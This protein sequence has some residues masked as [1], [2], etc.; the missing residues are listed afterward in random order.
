[1][2]I[3]EIKQ[4]FIHHKPILLYDPERENEVDFV[5]PTAYIQEST[6]NFMLQYGK[7]LLCCALDQD[8]LLKK[9]FF[10]L[11]SNHKDSLS[12]NFFIPV[13]HRSVYTGIS[14]KDRIATLHS[15]A[16][17]NSIEDY[18]YPG[19]V[20]LLGGIGLNK[21]KGHTEAALE[22]CEL[23]G[24]SRTA[25]I[26]E[27]LDHQ[28]ESHTI[29][30]AKSI[31]KDFDLPFCSIQD[32]FAQSIQQKPFVKIV[33]HAA[34]PTEFGNF[35]IVGF[36]NQLDTREHFALVKGDVTTGEVLVRIHSEC[37]TGDV[38]HSKK[39]DCRDQ[40]VK[41]MQLLEEAQKGVLIYMRQEG[42]DIGITNKI[43]TYA[44]QECGFDTYDAN[45]QIGHKAD[46]RD[47]AV[48]AQMIQQLQ[49]H[50]VK[51][52]TNN[53]SKIQG[54][55][56]YGVNVCSVHNVYGS[57]TAFNQKYIETKV[58]RFHHIIPIR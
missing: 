39:C 41:S 46:E 7:G 15:L 29:H 34:L 43:K 36:E 57:T 26:I 28:G 23:T 5:I 1:M 22:L 21:R 49:I 33:S 13:D 14:T 37:V 32:I 44:L 9:G 12:T 35:V 16:Q 56:Q 53:P 3:Q 4:C 24:C 50:S 11:P 2:N 51:L 52:I 20:S 55:R 54:L 48:A 25:T 10:P 27:L 58:K 6:L 40:L 30:Y 19:H 38:F 18:I 17:L 42:R 45:L 31:A 47:Y 8:T